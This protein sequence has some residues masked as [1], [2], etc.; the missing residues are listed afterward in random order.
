MHT[1]AHTHTH[2][3][4]HTHVHTQTRTCTQTHT[5]TDTYMHTNT[6]THTHTQT[7]TCTYTHT[8]APD[9]IVLCHAGFCKTCVSSYRIALSVCFKFSEHSCV[10][11]HMCVFSSSLGSQSITVCVCVCL[12][13]SSLSRSLSR[14]L[15]LSLWSVFRSVVSRYFYGC[16]GH[17]FKCF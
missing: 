7:R 6:H 10:S 5:H 17:R 11:T 8:H 4:I 3:H 9:S 15:A 13:S 16:L 2:T 1:H 12:L 14:S